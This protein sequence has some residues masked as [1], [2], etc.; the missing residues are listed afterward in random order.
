MQIHAIINGQPCYTLYC[1]MLYTVSPDIPGKWSQNSPNHKSKLIKKNQWEH[2]KHICQVISSYC[3]S[4]W[5]QETPTCGQSLKIKY[6]LFL[7]RICPVTQ[8]HTSAGYVN[9]LE[10]IQMPHTHTTAFQTNLRWKTPTPPFSFMWQQ[11]PPI[12]LLY[13]LIVLILLK[14]AFEGACTHRT[15]F[16]RALEQMWGKQSLGNPYLL[17]STFEASTYLHSLN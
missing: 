14:K 9:K 6:T 10:C 15:G 2:E 17:T 3:S 11:I 13:L 5:M 4:L 12:I 16:R 8:P 7:T 1:T